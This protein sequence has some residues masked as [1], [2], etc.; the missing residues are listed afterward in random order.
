MLIFHFKQVSWTH[1]LRQIV[2]NCYK[3]HG[4]EDLLPA[5]SEEEDKS[6]SAVPGTSTQ[7]NNKEK[8]KNL[9][10]N[11]TM[12]LQSQSIN[13][14]NLTNQNIT[15]V[16]ISAADVTATLTAQGVNVCQRNARHILIAFSHFF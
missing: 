8:V 2:I 9:N 3:Y 15:T 6:T 12:T 14:A 16:P 10:L 11:R 1:A 13:I 4:R 7:N 5:F